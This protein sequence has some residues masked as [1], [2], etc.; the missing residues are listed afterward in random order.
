MFCVI[1]GP[2]G[3]GK[4]TVAQ[5]M[6]SK[7]NIAG[8]TVVRYRTPGETPLGKL[9]RSLLVEQTNEH[10][11]KDEVIRRL[12]YSADARDLLLQHEF[13][14]GAPNVL[15]IVDRWELSTR[16]YATYHGFKEVEL[17]RALFKY[18][19][20]GMIPDVQILLE[21]DP[22]VQY[23]RMTDRPEGPKNKDIQITIEGCR[24]LT[25]CYSKA[26]QDLMDEHGD[27]RLNTTLIHT[28]NICAAK[29]VQK[30]ED[31][32]LERFKWTREANG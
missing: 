11:P 10:A 25:Q 20:K 1:E 3:V 4:T 7:S 29:V 17:L 6:F 15:V 24:W 14:F 8:V 19:L 9:M 13:E 2:N 26:V 22:E 28:N 30:A 32:V 16:A 27:W 12:L 5:G 18:A 31:V 21:A 23:Q